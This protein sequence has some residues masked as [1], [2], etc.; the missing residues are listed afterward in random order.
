MSKKEFF[1]KSAKFFKKRGYYIVLSLCILT[2]GA[3]SFVSYKSAQNIWG[4]TELEQDVPDVDDVAVPKTG[5]VDDTQPAT[6]V[7]QDTTT[8]P[9]TTAA[10]DSQKTEPIVEQKAYKMP[11][12]GNI[13]LGFS[14]ENP[15][16]SNTLKDWRIH[17]GIDIAAEVGTLVKAAND[18][19][20]EEIIEDDLL[21]ITVVIKHTDGKKSSYSNLD[22]ELSVEQGQVINRSDTI[23]KVGQSSIIEISD[24]PHLHFE[25]SQDGKQLDPTEICE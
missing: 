25:M 13:I 10:D 19:V 23:G 2:I 6:E 21:G 18:G 16:Y 15:V 24:A 1:E 20:V 7:Q 14:L 8:Q 9:E 17:T 12:S 5:V 11:V 3:I 22:P 4:D